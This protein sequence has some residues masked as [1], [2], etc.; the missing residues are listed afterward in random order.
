MGFSGPFL[1]QNITDA[2]VARHRVLPNIPLPLQPSELR[3]LV[4]SGLLLLRGCRNG[5]EV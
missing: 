5:A 4:V 2:G 3:H 1:R